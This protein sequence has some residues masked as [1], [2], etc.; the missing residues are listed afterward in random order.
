LEA[1]AKAAARSF[2]K[3]FIVLLLPEFIN[4]YPVFSIQ[5]QWSVE[6]VKRE[7]IEKK[8][9]TAVRHV[10]Q[11][12]TTIKITK[13]TSRACHSQRHQLYNNLCYL[14]CQLQ[15]FQLNNNFCHSSK[16]FLQAHF[17][18]GFSLF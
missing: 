11:Y 10:R 9:A 17:W 1:A 5:L 18:A 6:S 13:I 7:A 15:R 12:S 4:Q 14:A 8:A 3:Y 2:D 16:S